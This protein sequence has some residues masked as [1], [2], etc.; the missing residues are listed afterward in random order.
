MIILFA[1]NNGVGAET[2]SI[3]IIS[4]IRMKTETPAKAEKGGI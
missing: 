3:T 2:G 4:G 1:S